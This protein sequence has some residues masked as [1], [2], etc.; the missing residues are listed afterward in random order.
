MPLEML[1]HKE[2]NMTSKCR[3]ELTQYL[4]SNNDAIVSA[5]RMEL[6][7]REAVELAQYVNQ[8]GPL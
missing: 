7:I 5:A 8:N 1:A 4:H 2:H 6:E 3:A